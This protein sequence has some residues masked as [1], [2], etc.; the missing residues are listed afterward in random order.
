MISDGNVTWGPNVASLL[1]VAP[2]VTLG[3]LASGESQ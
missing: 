1:H 2:D 3:E